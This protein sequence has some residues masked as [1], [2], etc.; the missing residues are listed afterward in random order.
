MLRLHK[1]MVVLTIENKGVGGTRKLRFFR[2][3]ILWFGS[4]RNDSTVSIDVMRM[5]DGDIM[6]CVLDGGSVRLYKLAR[7]V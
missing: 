7:T 4:T 6:S 5:L 3:R 2:R 1:W